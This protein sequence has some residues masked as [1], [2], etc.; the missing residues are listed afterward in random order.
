MEKRRLIISF[1]ILSVVTFSLMIPYVLSQEEVAIYNL[2]SRANDPTTEWATGTLPTGVDHTVIPFGGGPD[3]AGMVRYHINEKLNDG[4]QYPLLLETHPKWVDNGYIQGYYRAPVYVPVSGA[5]L[6]V[7]VG[8]LEGGFAGR[9]TVQ[10][11]LIVPSSSP[12]RLIPL[13]N[14]EI[15]YADG[16]REFS[17]DFPSETYG[18]SYEIAL[19][20]LAGDT[21]AQDWV[22]WARIWITARVGVVSTTTTTTTVTSATTS[23]VTTVT[24]ETTGTTSTVTETTGTT[25]TSTT[26]VVETGLTTTTVVSEKTQTT[27]VT[28]TIPTTQT[29]FTTSIFKETVVSQVGTGLRCLIATAAFGS[30]LAQPVQTL[31]DYRD[32]FVLQT[33]GGRT[34]M[35]VFNSFYYSWSPTIAEQERQNQ[36]LREAI[37]YSIYPLIGV[38]DTSR[39]LTK[40]LWQIHPEMSVLAAGML[41]SVLLGVIYLAPVA[42]LIRLLVGRRV[43]TGFGLG[44]MSFTMICMAALFFAGYAFSN[45]LLTAFAASAVVLSGLTLGCFIPFALAAKIGLRGKTET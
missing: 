6:R 22:T 40:P 37:K 29:V 36:L 19:I 7:L 10:I 33:F 18:N 32:G 39:T 5:K 20:V 42:L 12:V 17:V 1:A 44:H 38:L 15:A 23:T 41:T 31:R 26:T 14:E 3:P 25:V 28:E 43:K 9:A 34:F 16:V 27:T 35:D 11:N 2:I 30:E 45:T 13:L 4:R 21:S 24:T 8:F